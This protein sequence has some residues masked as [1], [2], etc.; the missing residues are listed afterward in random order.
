VLTVEFY[1]KFAA[2]WIASWNSHSVQDIL[3]HYDEAFEFS[4]PVL[5]KVNPSS[6][7]TLIGTA[8]ARAYWSKGLAARPDLNFELVTL[9]KGVN[10]VVI[11]Y[12]GL[13]GK[14]CAEF[15][16][17]GPNGKVISS[18]AHGE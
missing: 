9:L 1:E 17:F 18:H 4:S 15:F 13:G 8:A 7:G 5:A 16:A 3:S 2:D 12:K 6:G 11:Y 14:L 10:S